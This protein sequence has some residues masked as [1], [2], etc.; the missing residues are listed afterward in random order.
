METRP[1]GLAVVG[2]TRRSVARAGRTKIEILAVVTE[3][4]RPERFVVKQL[5]GALF[6]VYTSEFRLSAVPIGTEVRA[7]FDYEVSLEYVHGALNIA[8]L[9]NAV[10]NTLGNFLKGLKEIAELKPIG[11]SK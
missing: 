10:A 3:A 5:P 6:K 1:R 4:K 11:S 7:T 8:L 9:E 2:Q